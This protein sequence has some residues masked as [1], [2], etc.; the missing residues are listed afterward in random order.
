MNKSIFVAMVGSSGAGKNTVIWR[1]LENNKNAKFLV[2]HTSRNMR[3]GDVDGVNYSFVSE[4]EFED[5]IRRDDFVEYDITHKGYYGV[6]KTTVANMLKNNNVVLKDLSMKGVYG[7]EKAVEGQAGFVS[8]FLTAG[9]CELKTRLLGRGEKDHKA[10]LSI[11]D[12]EQAKR[13]ECDYIITNYN[14]ERT[15][16]VVEA[17]IKMTQNESLLT[18]LCKH[19]IKQKK[20]EKYKKLLLSDKKLKPIKVEEFSGKIYILNGREKY[21]ASLLLEKKVAKIFECKTKIKS[22]PNNKESLDLQTILTQY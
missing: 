6:S 17:I 12:E 13:F 14:L 20:V 7:I 2:S 21:I 16:G 11:Y 1:I 4:N 18:P 15:V 9:K 3:D 22:Q 19:K 5:A 10:R 8:I